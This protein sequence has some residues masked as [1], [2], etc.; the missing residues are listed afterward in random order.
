MRCDQ[1]AG[2]VRK[3]AHLDE[4]AILQ[5]RQARGLDACPENRLRVDMHRLLKHEE[6]ARLNIDP[7]YGALHITVECH[8]GHLA[9]IRRGHTA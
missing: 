3:C 9:T 2:G 8:F 5:A 4:L 6:R 1:L 7:R